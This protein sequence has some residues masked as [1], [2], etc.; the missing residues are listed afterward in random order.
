LPGIARTPANIDMSGFAINPAAPTKF[1]QEHRQ[2]RLAT[3]FVEIQKYCNARRLARPRHDWPRRRA[4]EPCNEC[5]PFHSI[6][7]SARASS[8][9]GTSRLSS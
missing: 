5:A 3:F 6:T 4:P 7:L 8:E 1:L 2:K 9:G